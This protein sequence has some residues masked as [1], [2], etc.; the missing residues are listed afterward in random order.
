MVFIIIPN[1]LKELFHTKNN[2]VYIP[3]TFKK[4][5]ALSPDP[6]TLNG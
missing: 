4:S 2:N 3:V 5:V 1:E 6:I